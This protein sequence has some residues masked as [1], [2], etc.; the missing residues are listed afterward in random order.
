MHI[1]LCNDCGLSGISG[2]AASHAF[3]VYVGNASSSEIHEKLPDFKGFARS[4]RDSATKLR[5]IQANSFAIETGR[6][7]AVRG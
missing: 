1:R 2:S 3:G 7:A 4:A 5:E 6:E